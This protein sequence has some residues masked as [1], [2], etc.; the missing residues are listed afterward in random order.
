MDSNTGIQYSLL[1]HC[2]QV[3]VLVLHYFEVYTIYLLIA[4]IVLMVFTGTSEC[5]VLWPCLFDFLYFFFYSSLF[6]RGVFHSDFV[7]ISA[8]YVLVIG[9]NRFLVAFLQT[10]FPKLLKNETPIMMTAFYAFEVIFWSSDS[11]SAT[12]VSFVRIVIAIILFCFNIPM[13][14]KWTFKFLLVGILIIT[15]RYFGFNF[16][17][18]TE[19]LQFI[20]IIR[21]TYTVLVLILLYKTERIVDIDNSDSEN[22][23]VSTAMKNVTDIQPSNANSTLKIYFT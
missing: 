12:L 1:F 19:F 17:G 14:L 18:E 8:L 16:I 4:I 2:A 3:I 23:I 5:N 21:D 11:L 22:S 15:S 20:N 7:F 9:N 6:F 10:W 13:K